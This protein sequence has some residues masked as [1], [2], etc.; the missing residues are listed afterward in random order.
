MPF[1]LET[2][3]LILRQFEKRDLEALVTYRSDPQ[4]AR[5]QDWD[6]PYPR[7]KALA[8]LEEAIQ[9]QPTPGRWF[10]VAIESKSSGETLGECAFFWLEDGQQ[11]QIVITLATRHQRQGYAR[12]ALERLLEYLFE[13]LKLHR[14]QAS[15]DVENHAAWHLMIQLGMRLEGQSIESRWLKGRWSSEYHYALLQGEWR[16]GRGSRE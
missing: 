12:E 3:R 11:A 6:V 15:A 13:D 16:E 8:F 2:P 9:A 14:V 1:R 4:V 10:P 5:H 7:E